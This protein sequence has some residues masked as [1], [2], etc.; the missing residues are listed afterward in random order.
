MERLRSGAVFTAM[1]S[2]RSA[3]K[4]ALKFC[5]RNELRIKKEILLTKFKNKHSKHFWKEVRKMKGSVAP[6]R[7]IDGTSDIHD[8]VKIFDEKYSKILN[9]SECQT[10]TVRDDPKRF[11]SPFSISLRELDIAIN[12]LKP[13]KGF[14][15]IT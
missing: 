1:K 5:R 9:N 13:G 2:S 4:K 12:R 6:S 15:N 7:C 14:D 3:S 10:L 11:L 8:V